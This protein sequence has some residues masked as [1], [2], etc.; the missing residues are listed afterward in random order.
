MGLARGSGT[1][2]SRRRIALAARRRAGCSLGGVARARGEAAACCCCFVGW[3]GLARVCFAPCFFVFVSGL[4]SPCF[5]PFSFSFLF[6]S[7]RVFFSA[8][9]SD[10]IAQECPEEKRR[11]GQ[12]AG[13]SARRQPRGLWLPG[14]SLPSF[15]CHYSGLW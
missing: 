4:G 11:P 14:L 5:F 15:D 2:T 9:E 1:G 6:S 8:V 13:G 7:S 12:Q 10:L 3:D